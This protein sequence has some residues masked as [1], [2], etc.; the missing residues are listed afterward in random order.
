MTDTPLTSAHALRGT[1]ETRGFYDAWASRYEADLLAAGYAT[2]ARIAGALHRTGTPTEARV[3]D[4]GCGTGLSGM[5][6]VAR[7]YTRIDGCDLSPEMMALAEAR[8]IYG[9]LHGSQGPLPPEI[10][11][12][13]HDVI[14]ATGA[15]GHGAGPA[16]LLGDLAALLPPGGRLAFSLN[17]PTLADPAYQGALAALCDGGWRVLLREHGPHLPQMGMGATVLVLERG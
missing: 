12:G 4:F 8:Q 9:R 10:L 16:T 7:G 13:D 14:T 15:I 6:L 17:D 3:L 1:S 2:P 5:A 11:P